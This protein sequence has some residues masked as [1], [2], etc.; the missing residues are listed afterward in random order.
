[1][2]Q[3][4]RTKISLLL[5][6]AFAASWLF[7][8]IGRA[9]APIAPPVPS[10]AKYLDQTAGTMEDEAVALALAGNG[11]L[12]ALRK[13]LDATRA[14]LK[15]AGLRANPKLD[16]SGSQ[17]IGGPDNNQMAELMLPLELGG[18]RGARIAV[19]TRELEARRFEIANRERLLAAEVR[20]KFGEALAAIFK[21]NIAESALAAAQ[22]SFD[23]VAARVSEGKIAP[24]EQNIFLVEVNRLRSQ[25]ETAEGKAEAAMFELCNMIGK[26]PDESLRLRGDF[27]GM[28]ALPALISDSTAAA[29]NRRPD[30]QGAKAVELLADA[31]IEMAKSEGRL[32]ASVK[33]GYQRMDSSF[34][35]KGYDDMGVLRPIQERFHFFTFG[36]EIDLPVL[37]RNQG[38][39]E[40]ANFE[41]EAAQRRAEFG[42]LS[43]RRDVA[44]AIARYDRAA[45]ALSIFRGGVR[46]Q[47]SS[48]LQVIWQTYE[49]G[50]RSLLDYIAEERRFIDI[51]NELIDAQFETYAA[52]IEIMKATAAPELTQK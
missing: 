48:N 42:E 4:S 22:Q 1:M 9:Q 34:M 36:V 14:M 16:A 19:A 7:A 18:R 29:L 27:E 31:R 28:I 24:L 32:D 12:L 35:L 40:S 2:K 17:Q 3:N 20:L 6:A 33:A 8:V 30:L 51:E 49:L 46:D 21:L 5:L 44:A 11:E 39:I 50:A 52:R 23:L 10:A 45:R 25:R 15:Q 43:I 13:E 47:A 38:A 41:R 26:R 37:N